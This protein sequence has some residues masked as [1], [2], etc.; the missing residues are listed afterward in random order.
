[1]KSF[2]ILLIL[3]FINLSLCCKGC[4]DLDDLTFGKV[5]KKFKTVIVKLDQKF[6]YGETHEA[7]GAL[8]DAISNKTVSGF[9][10]PDV[11]VATVGILDYGELDNKALGEKYGIVTREDF[12]LI[13]LFN[14]GDLENPIA[15]EIG[16][17][18]I[19]IVSILSFNENCFV[20]VVK[21]KPVT[22]NQLFWFVKANAK[23]GVLVPGCML[24]LDRLADSFVSEPKK[25]KEILKESEEFIEKIECEEV[26]KADCLISIKIPTKTFES[27]RRRNK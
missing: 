3:S 22:L 5:I 24:E 15:L 1:M 17:I 2:V 20:S 12:P 21:S 9:D 13:R 26:R 6:P 4:V 11:L 16:N 8:A 27:F 19:L 7:F 10:H 23:V 25:R 18:K 14:D